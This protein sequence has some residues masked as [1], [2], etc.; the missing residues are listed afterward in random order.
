MKMSQKRASGCSH[1]SVHT[2]PLLPPVLPGTV[3]DLATVPIM[4]VG[5]EQPVNCTLSGLFPAAEAN[6]HLALGDQRLY[7]TVIHEEDFLSASALVK[8]NAE[9]EGTQ[10]LTC[11]VMLGNL[12]RRT[13]EQVTI[14]SK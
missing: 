12:S 13:Q 7:P 8:A 10:Q 1:L 2:D 9:E 6:V 3:P 14:Y 11:V 5:T 4:E